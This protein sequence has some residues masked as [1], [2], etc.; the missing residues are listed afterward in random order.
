LECEFSPALS[1][2]TY[3]IRQTMDRVLDIFLLP[4]P[5]KK[6]KGRARKSARVDSDPEAEVLRYDGPDG[7]LP[8]EDEMVSIDEWEK[9][10]GRQLDDLQ[11]DQCTYSYDNREYR[12]DS[13][14]TCSD[15]GYS[16]S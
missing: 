1:S 13:Q 5:A 4:P 7:Q 9:L 8:H 15:L 3:L 12:N 2:W 10:A 11:Y 6:K 16:A 14:L